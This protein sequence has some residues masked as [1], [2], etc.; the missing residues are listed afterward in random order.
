M[1]EDLYAPLYIV[2]F[3]KKMGYLNM[4]SLQ[5]MFLIATNQMVDPRFKET[6]ILICSHDELGALGLVLTQPYPGFL[7]TDILR[8]LDIEP[9]EQT[10]PE[11][12]CGGPVSLDSLFILDTQDRFHATRVMDGLYL[13]TDM[14]FV[15]HVADGGNLDSMRF[16]LGYAGW[17]AGQL[18]QEL[19]VNGWLVLP[20]LAQDVFAHAPEK[21]WKAVTGKYGIN[22]ELFNDVSG[23]A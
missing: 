4:D 20:S 18:E 7:F 22:I 15:T 11:L 19:G 16:F 10:Y 2:M 14:Q 13:G 12:Y 21:L 6:V 9:A 1:C 23:T 5:G 3:H 17:G 8:G